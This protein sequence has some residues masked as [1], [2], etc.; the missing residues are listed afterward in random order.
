MIEKIELYSP[1]IL[2]GNTEI[3]RYIKGT[4]ARKD[5]LFIT[6]KLRKDNKVI[7][8]TGPR[9]IGKTTMIYRVIYRL[10]RKF[11]VDSKRVL[12]VSLDDSEIDI[13]NLLDFYFKEIL[14]ES[15]SR[16]ID[17]VYIFI[18][19]A[20]YNPE[21][22]RVVKQYVDISKN[23]KFLLSG[24]SSIKNIEESYKYLA[25]RVFEYKLFPVRFSEFVYQNIKRISKDDYVIKD[26]F[27]FFMRAKG[28]MQS[29][30]KE[31][32]ERIFNNSLSLEFLRKVYSEAK[33]YLGYIYKAMES[34]MIYGAFPDYV[35]KGVYDP[36][37][38][39]SILL[40][41][42]EK[43]LS[44]LRISYVKFLE[45]LKL[46][47]QQEYTVKTINTI[48]EASGLNYKTVEKIIYDLNR[49]FLINLIFVESSVY[50]RKSKFKAYFID[51]GLRNSILTD[52]SRNLERLLRMDRDFYS[53]SSEALVLNGLYRI[54]YKLGIEEPDIRFWLD[55]DSEIDFYYKPLNL[56]IEV[57]YRESVKEEYLERLVSLD[58]IKI[59]V[60]KNE[61]GEYKGVYLVPLWLF[62]L[63]S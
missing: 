43:D 1:W 3:Y 33:R 42:L 47:A 41:T 35:Y 62:L 55:K 49:S 10:L 57:K 5:E 51:R 31:F 28:K 63:L 14:Q 30:Q 34:L 50:K 29:Y 39:K 17:D 6:N 19:E 23:V 40:E 60:T 11:D 25:G 58:G 48:S 36:L 45:V 9:R 20:Q 59:V 61:L 54:L 2:Y 24:S 12:Y 44:E 8:L 18:D 56:W 27:M 16:L 38:Y 53:S 32:R 26:S 22:F 37:L 13:K 52:F 7:L 4:I 15:P 21:S 46:L